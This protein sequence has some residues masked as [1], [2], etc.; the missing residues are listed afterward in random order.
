MNNHYVNIKIKK[1]NIM[2]VKIFSPLS[3]VTN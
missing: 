1:K 2:I 3:S